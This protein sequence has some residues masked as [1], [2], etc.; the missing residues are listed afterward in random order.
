MRSSLN[1][2][3]RYR[4]ALGVLGVILA[5]L[6][7]VITAQ[8]G[9]PPSSRV[10][11]P[12]AGSVP[13]NLGP[14]E[15]FQGT[16]WTGEP[17]ITVTVAELMAREALVPPYIGPPRERRPEQAEGVRLKK[18]Q[19]PYA[20]ALAE[21]P[22]APGRP[23]GAPP[24]FAAGALFL[25]PMFSES[26]YIPPDT[27]GDVGPTQV[28]FVANGRFKVYDKTG[29]LGGLNVAD[30]T[31]FSSVIPGGDG[32]SDP[33][34]RYDRLTGRWFI[35]EIS[36]NQPAYDNNRILIAVSSGSTITNSSSFTMYQFQHNEVGPMPNM[37]TGGF[38]DYD[39]L[40]VDKNALYI[41]INE[42][43]PNNFLN[44]T[45]YV[46]NKANLLVG[47]LT[48]TPFR[49]LLDGG[50]FAGPYTPQGVDNDDP[51]FNEGYFIG[52]DGA[53][54]SKL[55]MR[56]IINP[57]GTPSISGNIFVTVPT[58]YYPIDQVAQGSTH[59]LDALDD[60]LFAAAIH[61][62]KL[63][64]V[65]S[66]WTAH[67][68]LVNVSGVGGSGGDRNG[69]RWYQ[70]DNMTSTPALTQSGTVF[71]SNASNF[72]GNWIP[73]AVANGQGHAII[74][75]SLA[76]PALTPNAHVVARLSS[77]GPGN[78]STGFT[79]L[80][81]G[82]YN[83][84]SSTPQR[85]G[86]YSQSLVD[87]A[88][89]MTFWTFQE[90]APS[91]N[92]WAELVLK[93]FAPPPATP[94]STIGT[95]PIGVASAN[96][97]IVGTSSY[98]SGFFDPGAEVGGPGW[99]NHIA[100]SV[101]GG[102]VVNSATFLDPTHVRLNVDTTGASLGAKNVT[103][104]NPDG[105]NA[106]G[107]G[108]LSVVNTQVN[109]SHPIL[110]FGATKS[111]ASIADVTPPQ[112]VAVGFSSGSYAWTATAD[113]TWVQIT[114]GSGTGAG[115]FQ[116][117]IVN[118]GDVIGT[119]THLTANLNVSAPAATIRDGGPHLAATTVTVDLTVNQSPATAAAAFGRVDTPAQNAT[120]LQGAIG[121]T[122]WALDDVGV[123]DIKVYRTCFGFDNPASCQM[124]LGHNV[125]FVGTAGFVPGARPDVESAFPTYPQ[126]YRAGWGLQILS[127]Q[128]P[129]VPNMTVNGGQG[130]MA[131][132][133]V[134]TDEEGH[135]T[136][137]GR[138]SPD[139][140]PTSVT[141]NNDA[142]A[143]PFGTL[144]TPAQGATVSGN[145]ANFGWALTPDT[146]IVSGN[147]DILIGTSGSTMVVFIDGVS[148][149]TVA[150]NQCRGNVGNPV[151]AGVYCNDDVANI[152]GN[153]TPQPPLTPRS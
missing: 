55:T 54:F 137:L 52:V 63:T 90:V 47:T 64:G 122:G 11:V 49:G 133:A 129:H 125:V 116:V 150:Y 48:V 76:G 104:T 41:G 145:L 65:S 130:T 1:Q 128:L 102:V 24:Q 42:F 73:S 5:A 32:V 115:Q 21:W 39:T 100:A 120:G 151:P 82:T 72:N 25:G 132:F 62:N 101:S 110:Y 81:T 36:L 152:F 66:L 131:L 3:F 70:I 60:R 34:V 83:V 19:N 140:T 38:A 35:T 75:Q 142:I 114:G 67:N 15:Y 103:I 95:V 2:F 153:A 77:D 99:A 68:I 20:P 94:S 59:P 87:P 148:K 51:A 17:G 37:D 33:H 31:F 14:D 78:W 112:S 69:S 74:G 27:Q 91:T 57:G 45:G 149:G 79:I 109:A 127:N 144:D 98:G 9:R 121:L 135:Q 50:T 22:M 117:A 16:S 84:Q 6:A 119:A 30:D 10:Q 13:P 80:Y 12:M 53:V 107:A 61:K 7:V 56:R 147:G 43:D 92:E 113:K 85:W 71:D 111:G 26:G 93:V 118:P 136:L 124:V 134:A 8:Q 88:D 40:G 138:S 4:H 89:D 106:M 96:V 46:I 23:A 97:T 105:Q 141:L 146:D 108:I 139:H 28:L 44:T 123:S 29:V 58:T 86:D 126:A 143:K 18:A